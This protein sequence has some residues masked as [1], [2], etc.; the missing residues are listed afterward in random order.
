[1]IYYS[2]S[3]RGGP[4]MT[5]YTIGHSNMALERFVDLLRM[6]LIQMLVDI[7]SQPSSRYAPQFNRE[8]LKTSL[9]YTGI[10]YFYLGD[11]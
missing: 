9:D 7:R 8:P 4:H 2:G 1:M 11:K 10:A 5:I 3:P 6:Q